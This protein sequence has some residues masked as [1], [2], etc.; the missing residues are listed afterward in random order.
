MT[1]FLEDVNPSTPGLMVAICL[2]LTL[3]G[4]PLLSSS[5]TAFDAADWIKPPPFLTPF[6]EDISQIQNVL[7][8]YRS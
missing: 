6:L 1:N 8:R 3:S 7:F 2:G 4:D 5:K